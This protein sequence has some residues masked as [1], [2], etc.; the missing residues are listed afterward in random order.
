MRRVTLLGLI[1]LLLPASLF[2]QAAPAAAAG[3]KVAVIDFQTALAGNVEGKK[4]QEQ[5]GAE[6]SKRQ[7]DMEKI[8]KSLEDAQ[9]KL[10]TQ[11]RALSDT[12]RADLARDI[13]RM[14]TE[15]QRKNDDAQRELSDIQQK[16][17]KPIA[18]RL[19]KVLQAYSMEM[20][21]AV[22]LDAMSVVYFQDGAD[23]T[24]EI[25]RRFDADVA[26]T[27]KPAAAP[28]AK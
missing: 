26:A 13:D 2:A 28:A 12:A 18:E 14:N 17:L 3:T 15:L 7:A 24:M 5:L 25:I 9:N 4:A 21:Y 1:S 16:L 8:Q 6:V 19:Q 10:R 27:A 20:G 11:D 22:V 23:I